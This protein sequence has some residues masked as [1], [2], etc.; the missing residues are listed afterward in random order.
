MPRLQLRR[1]QTECCDYREIDFVCDRDKLRTLLRVD[2]RNRRVISWIDFIYIRIFINDLGLAIA[3]SVNLVRDFV[4]GRLPHHDANQF[5]ASE[6]DSLAL[7]LFR[8]AT[9]V[10]EWIKGKLE[11]RR[12]TLSVGCFVY[13]LDERFRHGNFVRTIF[14]ERY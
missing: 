8:Y 2:F 3:H 6:F 11:I 10:R 7:D 1:Q 5:V 13:V 14:S 12:W 9:L 4:E